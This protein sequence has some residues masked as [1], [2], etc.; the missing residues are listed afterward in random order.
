M[1]GAP[2]NPTS[3]D[4]VVVHPLDAGDAAIAAA[5]RAGRSQRHCVLSGRCRNLNITV[6][7][8]A[9]PAID[10]DRHRPVDR[11]LPT[12]DQLAA[13]RDL[14]MRER[15]ETVGDQITDQSGAEA[16]DVSRVASR[17]VKRDNHRHHLPCGIM[18]IF[19]SVF[20]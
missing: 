8:F 2:T 13:G 5:A 10:A 11:A 19:V 18:F 3:P 15:R 17:V 14:L 20:D 16:V 12:F 7:S 1:Q 4:R 9:V 6:A